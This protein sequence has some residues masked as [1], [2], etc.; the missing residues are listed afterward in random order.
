MDKTFFIRV[1]PN[2]RILVKNNDNGET[3]I[4]VDTDMLREYI[5]DYLDSFKDKKDDGKE[6]TKNSDI[7][8]T[9]K[10]KVF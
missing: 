5:D 6:S 7:K 1:L 10:R 2:G 8:P 4:V 3:K 9:V